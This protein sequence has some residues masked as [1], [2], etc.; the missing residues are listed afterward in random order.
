[1]TNLLSRFED[2]RCRMVN[3]YK[4][5]Y[6]GQKKSWRGSMSSLWSAKYHVKN[7]LDWHPATSC[8]TKTGQV[9]PW[10]ILD[11]GEE[12]TIGAVNLFAQNKNA[13]KMA[14]VQVNP[15]FVR[16]GHMSSYP[17]ASHHETA[18]VE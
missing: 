2:C 7:C 8:S 18:E 16:P 9:A 15:D 3:L 10:I 4:S 11:I 5:I 6:S 14:N 1:M 17:G 12:R 13:Y